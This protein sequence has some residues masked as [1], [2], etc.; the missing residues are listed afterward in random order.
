MPF[1]LW[2]LFLPQ[3][4]IVDIENPDGINGPVLVTGR[5]LPENIHI[6]ELQLAGC[7]GLV[8]QSNEKTIL[9]KSVVYDFVAKIKVHFIV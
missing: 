9:I 2:N 7:V 8:G 1:C 3:V 5:Q 4:K 6:P